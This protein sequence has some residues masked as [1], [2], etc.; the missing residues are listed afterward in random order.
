MWFGGLGDVLDIEALRCVGQ[1]LLD[2]RDAARLI[3]LN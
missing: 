1:D 2:G 3:W